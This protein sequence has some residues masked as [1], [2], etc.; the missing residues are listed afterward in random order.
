MIE[1]SGGS[2]GQPTGRSIFITQEILNR[3]ELPLVCTSFCRSVRGNGILAPILMYL[4]LFRLYQTKKIWN[5]QLQSTGISNFQYGQF[6]KYERLVIPD[7]IIQE[8]IAD[9]LYSYIEYGHLN[10]NQKLAALRDL[11]LPRLMRGELRV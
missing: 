3:F 4:H 11:L 6:N 7:K 10:E 9:T 1:I 5:Y 2:K 8:K